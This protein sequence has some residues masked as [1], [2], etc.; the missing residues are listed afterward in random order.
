MVLPQ[1]L[2]QTYYDINHK[3]S[4]TV[5]HHTQHFTKEL[6]ATGEFERHIHR[7]RKYYSKKINLICN[8]LDAI[9]IEYSG[10]HTG[11]HIMLY[12]IAPCNLRP[13]NGVPNAYIL[14]LGGESTEDIIQFIHTLEVLK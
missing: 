8:E 10:A 12:N 6:M 11:M 1:H 7:S 4:Q 5:P 13:V 14:G 9:G 3:E 2:L